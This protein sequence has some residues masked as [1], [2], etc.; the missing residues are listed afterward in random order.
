[1]RCRLEEQQVQMSCG[2]RSLEARNTLTAAWTWGGAGGPCGGLPK[3]L[4]VPG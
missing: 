4:Y 1:M 3:V 2:P